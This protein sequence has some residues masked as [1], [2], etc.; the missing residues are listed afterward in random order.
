LTG[1]TRQL[2]PVQ[3]AKVED[4]SMAAIGMRLIAAE[5]NV[6][7]SGELLKVCVSEPRLL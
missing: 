2:I 7:I 1:V 4:R 3:T 5:E 6:L